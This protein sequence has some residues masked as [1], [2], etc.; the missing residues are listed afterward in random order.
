VYGHFH[1]QHYGEKPKEE[2]G[3]GH[4]HGGKGAADISKACMPAFD[5]LDYQTA[6]NGDIWILGLPLFQHYRVGFDQKAGEISFDA[7]GGGAGCALCSESGNSDEFLLSQ[8]Q[9]N[10]QL[11]KSRKKLH[12]LKGSPRVRTVAKNRPL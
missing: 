12:M 9:E 3:H 4:H 7:A 6:S 8:S 1:Q 11:G 5:Q 2:H 10:E